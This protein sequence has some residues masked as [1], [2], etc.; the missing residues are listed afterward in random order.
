MI[1]SGQSRS[2]PD[3]VQKL[4]DAASALGAYSIAFRHTIIPARLSAGPI[5][6]RVR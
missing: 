6:P 3:I 1:E 2:N 4:D 5:P